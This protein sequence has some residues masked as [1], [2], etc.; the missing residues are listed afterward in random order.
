MKNNTRL[1]RGKKPRP[2]QAALA[3]GKEPFPIVGIGA[4][5]G[6]LE[7]F[8]RLLER[9]PLDTGMAFVLVQHLDPAHE[10][11]LTGLLARTTSLPVRE[12]TNNLAVEPDHIYVIPPN[13]G[14]AMTHGVLR[15]EPRKDAARPQR[16]IDSFFESLAQDQREC[17]IGIILSGTGSDGSV[18]LEA[19]KAEG[20]FT[21][22][23]DESARYDSMPRN[24]IAAGCVDFVL[25]PKG[26]AQELARI[27]KHPYVNGARKAPSASPTAAEP[28]RGSGDGPAVPSPEPGGRRRAGSEDG[29]KEILLLVRNHSGVDFSLYKRQTIE[30]RITRRMVLNKAGTLKGYADSLRGNTKELGALYSDLLISVTSFFRNP[31]AFEVLRRKVFPKLVGRPSG[32]PVRAWVL[33][34]S[35][36]QEAYSIA[37]AFSEFCQETG[38]TSKLQVFATD[39]N[40]ALLE[41]ARHGLYAKSFTRDISRSGCGA[42]SSRSKAVTG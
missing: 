23:Q 41:K 3:S 16:A 28:D 31:E 7:A 20:G 22:A 1:S 38:S 9:L 35:T 24:A 5:A 15:L 32:E 33:G 37:M 2:Q 6:G 39:L 25:S 29:L 34:C 27:A 12:V 36:G 4:S 8:T 42:S 17:A 19:I 10:S 13:A 21:F 30:R 40:E 18:G 14:L 26:I 11:A